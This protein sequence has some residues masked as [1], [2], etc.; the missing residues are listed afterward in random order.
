[1]NSPENGNAMF[2]EENCYRLS[3][4]ISP[5][6]DWYI[7]DKSKQ[8]QFRRIWKL[9]TTLKSYKTSVHGGVSSEK[10]AAP[11]TSNWFRKN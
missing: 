6:D 8:V 10:M 3:E 7:R 1:M 9:I 4:K 11:Q 5:F 2:Q